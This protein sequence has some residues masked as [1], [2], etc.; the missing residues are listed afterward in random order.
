MRKRD[1]IDR[2]HDEIRELVDDLWHCMSSSS[3]PASTPPR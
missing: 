1:D 2:L 3:F